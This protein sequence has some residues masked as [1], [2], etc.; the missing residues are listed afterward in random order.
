MEVSKGKEEI[1]IYPRKGRVRENGREESGE[2]EEP[3]EERR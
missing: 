3:G 2:K 1:R